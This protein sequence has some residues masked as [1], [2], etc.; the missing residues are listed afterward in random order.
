MNLEFLT[1]VV[2]VLALNE[3]IKHN[4]FERNRAIERDSKS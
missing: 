2:A 3:T 1:F 4:E